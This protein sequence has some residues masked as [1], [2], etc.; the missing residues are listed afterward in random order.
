MKRDN[1]VTAIGRASTVEA[2]HAAAIGKSLT[3]DKL[4]TAQDCA[5]II[6]RAR[7]LM[8]SQPK[9]VV[10][11]YHYNKIGNALV[12]AIANG[13]HQVIHTLA[14]QVQYNTKPR[15]AERL[16]ELITTFC[17][18]HDCGTK[19]N[20]AP[21]KKLVAYIADFGHKFS[22]TYPNEVPR[23]LNKTCTKM[24]VYIVNR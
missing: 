14:A 24:G 17:M 13:N 9:P 12:E 22:T 19:D 16:H 10:A 7:W 8:Q 4:E 23:S 18:C 20:P 21:V 15:R 11:A 5:A 3:V 1:P 2:K 6:A